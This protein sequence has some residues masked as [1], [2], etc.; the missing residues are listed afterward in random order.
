M[1]TYLKI[2]L[3]LVLASC[4]KYYLT[5]RQVPVNARSLAS[6]HVGSPDPRQINPPTG[7]QLV[8]DWVI[9]SDILREE[10]KVVLTLVF[11]N[12]TE[13]T[14]HY[15][16]YYRSG[17]V[18]Y[19]LVGE[20]YDTTGGLLTYRAEIVTGNGDVYRDWKHQLWVNLIQ[21]QD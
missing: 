4:S 8:I 14:R 21:M 10:P 3:L 16:I 13:E 19:N 17:Y 5:V 1:A 18:V 9:P 11:K 7:Q 12:H 15:P 6:S 20:E 2:F